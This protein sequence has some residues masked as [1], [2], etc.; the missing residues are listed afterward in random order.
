[1]PFIH[2]KIRAILQVFKWTK[3]W[4]TS[5]SRSRTGGR[6]ADR[7]GTGHLGGGGRSATKSQIIPGAAIELQ[8]HQPSKGSKHHFKSSSRAKVSEKS[9]GTSSRSAW[10]SDDDILRH[11]A[12]PTTARATSV[13]R[14]AQVD[15]VAANANGIAILKEVS[16]Q[17]SSLEDGARMSTVDWGYN[18]TVD[19][20]P[21]PNRF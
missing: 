2:P 5:S 1:M 13:R 12:A 20:G 4:V 14:P 17:N 7:T 10:G 15:V 9:L 3:N 16:V 6:S 21:N 18:V 11:D 19:K 8:D